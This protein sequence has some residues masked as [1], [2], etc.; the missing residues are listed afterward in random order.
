MKQIRVK[1]DVIINVTEELP[2]GMS[3]EELAVK[4]EHKLNIIV[5][6]LI[7]GP[8]IKPVGVRMHFKKISS[9]TLA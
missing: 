4:V 7:I 1:S 3:D 5:S 8:C 6:R 2:S 9:R